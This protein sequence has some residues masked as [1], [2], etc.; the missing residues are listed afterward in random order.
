MLIIVTKPYT[1][2]LTNPGKNPPQFVVT[3]GTQY[4]VTVAPDIE[5]GTISVDKEKNHMRVIL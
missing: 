1:I 3:Q 2:R 5:N 4:S